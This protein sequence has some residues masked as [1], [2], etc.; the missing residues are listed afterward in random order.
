M[1][2]LALLMFVVLVV[3]L[4]LGYPVAFTLGGTALIFGLLSQGIEERPGGVEVSAV[5]THE[6]GQPASR[7]RLR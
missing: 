4:L 6:E 3:F 1:E 7:C 5:C 2:Y